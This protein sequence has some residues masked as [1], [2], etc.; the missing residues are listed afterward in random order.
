MLFTSIPF[1]YYFF[2]IITLLYFLTPNQGKNIVL[3]M[4]SLIF[5]A[6]G[7]PR[8]VFVMMI[9]IVPCYICALLME[10]NRGKKS[11]CFFCAIS[12]MISLA[13][14]LYYKYMNFFMETIDRISGIGFSIPSIVLPIGISFYTFQMMSYT[15][16]VKRGESAQKNILDLALYVVMFPQL[17]AGPIVR[18]HDL[19]AQ[20]T[21]RTHSFDLASLGIRRFIIGMS[22]KVLIADQLGELCAA[23]Q[24][25]NESSVLFYWLYALALMFQLYFDFSGYS[26]MAIGLGKIFGFSFPENFT[27]PL[28]SSSITDFWRR[29]HISLG[30]WFKDYVYIPLGGNRKGFKRQM[31]YIFIVWFLTGL[32]HG[33][34]WNFIIWGLY[35]ALL[36]ILEKMWLFTIW[37]KHRMISHVVTFVLILISFLIF[38]AQSVDDLSMMVLGLFGIGTTSLLSPLALYNLKSFAI[39]LLIA[40]FGSGTWS[41]NILALLQKSN[42]GKTMLR[43]GEPIVLAGLLIMVSAYLVDGSFSPFLYFRF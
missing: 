43:Y 2:P 19:S 4:G 26:D 42:T 10:R 25:S 11:E 31:L 24:T 34:A 1:L 23:F 6:W 5:Y 35:F 9:S 15:I 16:D 7:E 17:I 20:M 12:I 29:W 22:K 14:L 37:K 40:A 21:K 36:L 8:N 18:Y 38:S 39:V 27:H 30:T 3:L 41:Q 32:W 28:T 13:F 33:A